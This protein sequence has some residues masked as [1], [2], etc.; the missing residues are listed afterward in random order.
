MDEMITFCGYSVVEVIFDFTDNLH[1]ESCQI[2]IYNR[3]DCG[4]WS[5]AQF[6]ST[7]KGLAAAIEALT[8]KRQPILSKRKLNDSKIQQ[9]VWRTSGF[10]LALRWCATDDA[11]E[12]IT[13]NIEK[14]N[15]IQDLRDEIKTDV[16]ARE[17]MSQVQKEVKGNRW[18]D[19][20]MVNQGEKWY[21]VVAVL[22]RLM[23]YYNSS[24]DQHILAQ[25]MDADPLLGTDLNRGMEA[26]KDNANKLRI[27]VKELEHYADASF[28]TASVFESCVQDYNRLASKHK[29]K[30]VDW[31]RLRDSGYDV[32]RFIAEADSTLLL[33]MRAKRRPGPKRFFQSVK[34][35]VDKGIPLVWCVIIMPGELREQPS[36]SF[37]LRLINGYN[38]KTSEIIYTDSWGYGHEK[39]SMSTERAWAITTKLFIIRPK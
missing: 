1:L 39:K 16:K 23:K 5:K 36:A 7:Q 30:K 13:V 18:I 9:L 3:G 17:L 21:C 28:R 25:I 8:K 15:S 31:T 38:E 24:I 19:V 33:E 14:R 27:N 34:E 37:H 2:S 12:Y 29:L 10:D 4:A 35:S 20:P 32:R 22:E 6:E 11:T 26:V